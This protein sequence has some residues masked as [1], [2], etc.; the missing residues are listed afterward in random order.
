[1]FDEDFKTLWSDPFYR[2]RK[3][4][5][6]HLWWGVINGLGLNRPYSRL[7]CKLGIYHQYQPGVCGYCGKRH[8]KLAKSWQWAVVDKCPP[9]SHMVCIERSS[10]NA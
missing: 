3:S 2:N 10:V 7:L 5:I 1:M 8:V 6:R 9:N 4:A